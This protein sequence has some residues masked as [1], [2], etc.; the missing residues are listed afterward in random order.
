MLRN[1]L[2]DR[3]SRA[4]EFEFTRRILHTCFLPVYRVFGIEA[5]HSLIYEEVTGMF[6]L[7]TA[8]EHSFIW[9]QSFPE[10]HELCIAV[11]FGESQPRLGSLPAGSTR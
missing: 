3:R 4:W 6:Q 2:H 8:L 5:G 9:S 7:G 10:I 1:H 11:K